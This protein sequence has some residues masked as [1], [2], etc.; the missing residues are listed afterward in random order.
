MGCIAMPA[1]R[2]ET[3]CRRFWKNFRDHMAA[4]V[5]SDRPIAYLEVGCFEAMTTR[6]L[7]D[8]PLGHP[9]STACVID[10]WFGNKKWA[11]SGAEVEAVARRNLEPYSDRVKIWKG[12]SKI[13][14]ADPETPHPAGGYDFIYLD[15]DHSERGCDADLH[16]CWPLLKVGGL[17]VCDDYYLKGIRRVKA[18]VDAFLAD[19]AH[20]H[21]VLFS[22][23]AQIGFFRRS[24]P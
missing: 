13:I 2:T 10:P 6:W 18:A 1:E 12:D 16:L 5:N 20:W 7:L 22:D 14:L 15:G 11:T 21:E 4:H 8:G 23:R 3:M 9:G 17:I 19:R 24:A